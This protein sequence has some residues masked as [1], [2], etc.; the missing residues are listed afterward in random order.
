MYNKEMLVSY[1]NKYIPYYVVFETNKDKV[2]ELLGIKDDSRI[3]LMDC[4][5][6]VNKAFEEK[7][8]KRDMNNRNEGRHINYRVSNKTNKLSC[9]NELVVSLAV[10]LIEDIPIVNIEDGVFAIEERKLEQ[11][12]QI[13]STLDFNPKLNLNVFD[14]VFWNDKTSILKND[15]VFFANSYDWFIEKE[16]PFKR[17]YLLYGP[18][19]CGKTISIRSIAQFFNTTPKTF[20]FSARYPAPDSAFINWLRGAS[21]NELIDEDEEN[22]PE[23]FDKHILEAVEKAFNESPVAD[24]TNAITSTKKTPHIK[25]FVLEDLDRYYPKDEEPKTSVSL[26]SIL[27]A[28]DGIDGRHNTVVIATANNPEN[29]DQKVLLRPGRFDRRICYD[30]PT[31]SQAVS[32]MQRKFKGDDSISEDIL[33]RV[34][35]QL[36]GHSYA[37]FN[38]LYISSAAIAFQNQR[39]SIV[40]EDLNVACNEHLSFIIDGLKDIK[41]TSVGFG[42]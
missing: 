34:A 1:Q 23:D 4:E 9:Y 24:M 8:L 32:F 12:E 7:L 40:D 19:G 30:F 3:I 20:D 14:K 15:I 11:F 26:S 6:F 27:N 18:P 25:L 22:N 36:K 29:L 28:L 35:K 17:S 21:I 10:Y 42:G 41:K 33:L 5:V 16:V 31:P 39:T 37:L 13:I 2:K 38:E